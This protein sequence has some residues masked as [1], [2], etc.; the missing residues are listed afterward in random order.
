MNIKLL[1]LSLATLIGVSFNGLSATVYPASTNADQTFTGNN[2][3]TK[4]VN[5]NTIGNATGATNSVAGNPLA[6]TPFVDA[7]SNSILSQVSSSYLKL[8]GG[9][10][11]GPVLSSSVSTNAPVPNEL[12]TANYVRNLLLNNNLLMYLSATTN[13][14]YAGTGVYTNGCYMY[15][16]TIQPDFNRAYTTANGLAAGKYIGAAAITNLPAVSTLFGPIFSSPYIGMTGGG[17]GNN[18]K[19][20]AEIYYSYD[21]GATMKG[22][23]DSGPQVVSNT[24]TNR[25]DFVV[26]VPQITFTNTA[27]VFRFLKVDSATAAGSTVYILGGTTYPSQIELGNDT[28]TPSSV[29]SVNVNILYSP[30]NTVTGTTVNF[31]S[32]AYTESDFA[33]N[34]S[35]AWA[36]FSGLINTQYQTKVYWVTNSTASPISFTAP[37][38]CHTLGT[39]N[40]T[41]VTKCVFQYSAPHGSNLFSLPL[42]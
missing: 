40:C 25:Y 24:T 29:M 35:F 7:A 8:V 22:D 34:A 16:N 30:T 41:Q 42:W 36:G 31:G 6:D 28:A 37:A 27:T 17:G 4:P 2:T 13:Q 10:A 33:T 9:T 5:A 15:T 19:L 32:T 14:N 18:V 20:H 38:N 3:F 23:W 39:L 26:S 1:L 21:N 11:S 12:V